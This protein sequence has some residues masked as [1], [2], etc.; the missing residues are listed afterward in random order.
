MIWYAHMLWDQKKACLYDDIYAFPCDPVLLS[1]RLK[2]STI[3]IL[4]YFCVLIFCNNSYIFVSLTLLGIVPLSQGVTIL[5][6]FLQEHHF[7]LLQ[8]ETEKLRGDIEKMRSELRSIFKLGM[9][10]FSPFG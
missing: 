8:R 3:F 4:F 5:L 9:K 7:S 6:L 1:F 10:S 2:S